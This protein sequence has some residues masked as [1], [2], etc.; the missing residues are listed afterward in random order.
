M[1][2]LR[3]EYKRLHNCPRRGSSEKAC[4][5]VACVREICPIS[6]VLVSQLTTYDS[7]IIQVVGVNDISIERGS[8]MKG[9]TKTQKRSTMRAVEGI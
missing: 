7:R 9:L 1:T 5:Y 4:R 8:G 6:I 3:T 2:S